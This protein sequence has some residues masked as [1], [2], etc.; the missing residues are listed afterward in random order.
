M[1]AKDNFDKLQLRF[2]T[3]IKIGV[4][5]TQKYMDTGEVPSAPKQLELP[6]DI[7]MANDIHTHRFRDQEIDNG[8]VH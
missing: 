6:L 1:K 4:I 3:A 5:P 7:D 2:K 8:T